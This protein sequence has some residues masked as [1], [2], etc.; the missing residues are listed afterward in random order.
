[1]R[2]WIKGHE[3]IRWADAEDTR[4]KDDILEFLLAKIEK[5]LPTLVNEKDSY[6]R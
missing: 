1:M 3:K 5:R 4:A 2:G 6:V